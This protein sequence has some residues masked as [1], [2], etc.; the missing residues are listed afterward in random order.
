MKAAA[1]LERLHSDQ[2]KL[3]TLTLK[4]SAAP[5][6]EQLT[7]L[8]SCFRR[9][10]QRTVWRKHVAAGFAVIEFTFNSKIRHWH[11]H[12]HI[13]ADSDYFPHEHLKNHWL[14][15]TQTS[16]IVDIRPCAKRLNITNYLAKYLGKPPALSKFD[17]ETHRLLE[18][19]TAL[20]RSR[21]LIRFGKFPIDTDVKPPND[22]HPQDWQQYA[23]Y[24]SVLERLQQRDPTA[25]YVFQC[26]THDTGF[27]QTPRDT[28][29]PWSTEAID[30]MAVET[31]HP[32]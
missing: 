19:R 5:L 31:L 3:I 16:S 2:L 8:R 26:L 23:S 1:C 30:D 21:L 9:L 7:R 14:S 12:I 29:N 20:D 15:I 18:F 6:S 28:N 32:T 13:I 10:R 17:H 24:E 11:P 25:I 22:E 4:S 27:A